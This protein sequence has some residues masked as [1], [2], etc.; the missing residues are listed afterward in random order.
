MLVWNHI[1]GLLAAVGLQHAPVETT[2]WRHRPPDHNESGA[3]IDLLINAD[4]AGL[5]ILELKHRDKPYVITK[6]E[7]KAL[8]EKRQVLERATQGR[9]SIF[10]HLLASAGV[11]RNAYALETVDYIHDVR[12]LF[13]KS[14]LIG[15][16]PVDAQ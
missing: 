14:D 8:L 4:K 10:I 12:S 7:N 6:V 5:Y 3:E 16:A 1:E 13:S 11:V 15:R 9:R 2:K